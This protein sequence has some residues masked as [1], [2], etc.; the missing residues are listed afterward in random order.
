MGG[1]GPHGLLFSCD[2]VAW[3]LGLT[4]SPLRPCG[5]WQDPGPWGGNDVKMLGFTLM[6]QER[7]LGV[8]SG[9]EGSFISSGRGAVGRQL[10]WGGDRWLIINLQVGA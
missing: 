2:Q 3:G 9:K 4:L 7:I 10:P 5:C 1:R 8:S 6:G